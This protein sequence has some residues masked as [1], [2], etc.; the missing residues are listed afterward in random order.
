[1]RRMA[2]FIGNDKASEAFSE[3]NNKSN[4]TPFSGG[5]PIMIIMDIK[6]NN[7]LA[8]NNF[9]MNL[10][11]SKEDENSLITPEA[12]KDRPNFCY[13][14]VAIIN[15]S[16]SSGKTTFGVLLGSV[17]NFINKRDVTYLKSAIG[18]KSKKAYLSMDLIVEK[19]KL[20]RLEVKIS[21]T[22]SEIELR[23]LET[24]IAK[25]DSYYTCVDRLNQMK[26]EYTSDVES[27]LAQLSPLH[28]MV[29]TKEFNS[30]YKSDICKNRELFIDVL[31]K[32]MKTL[33]P[34]IVS[35]K[36]SDGNIC[37]NFYNRQLI[38]K[39]ENSKVGYLLSTGTKEGITISLILSEIIN[40]Y[41]GF[42]YCDEKFSCI[43]SDIEISILIA[44]ISNL[45]EGSQLFFTT[46]NKELLSLRLPKHS[47]YFLKKELCDS[48]YS[49]SI[50]SAEEVLDSYS[51]PFCDVSIYDAVINDYFSSV[52]ETN[53]ITDLTK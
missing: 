33:D 49:I 16:N 7:F 40:N 31:N 21:H 14:K 15:G 32:V 34:S 5:K 23:V 12:F 13:K 20:Q 3:H 8:F 37:I 36:D 41:Y 43:D 17:F 51:K 2:S 19:Y 4:K 1:M 35:V 42:Y 44:M 48:C 11:F 26:T 22:K 53:L 38:L 9:H 46:H 24:L 45:A 47:F 30:I 52:P 50:S 27:A 6:V 39:D 29:L 28:W 18:D 25:D 10:A